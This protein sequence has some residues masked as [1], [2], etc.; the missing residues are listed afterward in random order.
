MAELDPLKGREMAG[1]VVRTQEGEEGV[2]IQS[3]SQG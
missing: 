1:I 3:D 2:R